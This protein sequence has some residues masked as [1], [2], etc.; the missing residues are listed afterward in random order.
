MNDD[1]L[2]IR[3]LTKTTQGSHIQNNDR[4]KIHRFR[5]TLRISLILGC[6]F[7]LFS[8]LLIDI[9]PS[10]RDSA[11]YLLFVPTYLLFFLLATT[12]AIAI[13]ITSLRSKM[14]PIRFEAIASI[15]FLSILLA[16]LATIFLQLVLPIVYTPPAI[17]SESLVV[18]NKCIEFVQNHDRYKNLTL[19]RWR[20]VSISGDRTYLLHSSSP[21][22]KTDEFFSESEFA[23]MKILAKQLHSIR[24]QRFR[25]DNDIVLFYRT[26]TPIPP[27]PET[28]YGLLPYLPRVAY[29]VLRILP[30]GPGVA[31]SLHGKNPNEIDSDVLNAAKPFIHISGNWYLSRHLM[32]RGSASSMPASI[33]KSLIDCSLRTEG[34][35]LGNG[36]D[37]KLEAETK[38]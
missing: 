19:S 30:S 2:D 28:P 23:E 5:R 17:T 25:R 15:V 7:F 31:Y 36:S 29:A 6:S 37:K 20:Y 12:M 32:F 24:C 11:L 1:N 9:F 18:F 14:A 27:V 38:G 26:L 3:R 16:L 33:P 21:W 22:D 34:L 13:K 35:N 4:K 8:F 10:F